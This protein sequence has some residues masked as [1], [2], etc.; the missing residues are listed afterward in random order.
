MK[1]IIFEVKLIVQSQLNNCSIFNL[2]FM[3][4]YAATALNCVDC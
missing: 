4:E 2:G 3:N 1:R